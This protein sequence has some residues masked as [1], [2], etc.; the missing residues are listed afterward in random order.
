MRRGSGKLGF[1]AVL[2]RSVHFS[3]ENAQRNEKGRSLS[4]KLTEGGQSSETLTCIG[5]LFSTG[6]KN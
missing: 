6:R 3:S 4:A 5:Q 2:L 1:G